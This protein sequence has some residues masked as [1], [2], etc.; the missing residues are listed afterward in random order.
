MH[1]LD[2]ILFRSNMN[3]LFMVLPRH[4]ALFTYNLLPS[5]SPNGILFIKQYFQ[6]K[7]TNNLQHV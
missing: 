3:S 5:E 6:I 4:C 1:H 2:M 7:M